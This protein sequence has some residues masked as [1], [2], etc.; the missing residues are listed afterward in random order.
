MLLTPFIISNQMK[1]CLSNK[2]KTYIFTKIVFNKDK[3]KTAVINSDLLQSLKRIVFILC[4]ILGLAS[5]V[6]ELNAQSLKRIH[7]LFVKL[8]LQIKLVQ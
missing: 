4:Y 7:F 6:L 5:T 1:L 2:N 8:V 3:K